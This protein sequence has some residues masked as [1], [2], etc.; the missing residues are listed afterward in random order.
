VAAGNGW[1][2]EL[3]VYRN[4][5]TVGIKWM[6]ELHGCGNK[7]PRPDTGIVRVSNKAQRGCQA[8]PSFV[9]AALGTLLSRA[10]RRSPLCQD[11]PVS[12]AA[13]V[14][15]SPHFSPTPS[16]SPAIILS[17][18]IAHSLLH[19]SVLYQ[20]LPQ[21][22]LTLFGERKLLFQHHFESRA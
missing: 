18:H 7:E 4:Q 5:M 3:G 21:M 17:T 10:L 16:I 1:L 9:L 6:M 14:R 2:W 12:V 13:M 8:K 22:Q 15:H 20:L 19:L 11:K